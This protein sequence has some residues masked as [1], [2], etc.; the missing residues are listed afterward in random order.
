MSMFLWLR[1]LC[2]PPYVT[3]AGD[4]VGIDAA[5]L[6]VLY[7]SLRHRVRVDALLWQ[8]GPTLLVRVTGTLRFA[9]QHVIGAQCNNGETHAD[10]DGGVASLTGTRKKI[11][12]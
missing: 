9:R 6:S 12:N 7:A 1:R 11:V 5:S 4:R 8:R 10:S 3:G 2:L